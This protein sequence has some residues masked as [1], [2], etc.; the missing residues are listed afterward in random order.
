LWGPAD[1]SISGPVKEREV[2]LQRWLDLERATVLHG[3]VR[4]KIELTVYDECHLMFLVRSNSKIM[5][6]ASQIIANFNSNNIQN[7]SL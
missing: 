3:L 1:V 6:D 7:I 2:T 4:S 5:C